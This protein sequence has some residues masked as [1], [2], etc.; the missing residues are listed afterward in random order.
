MNEHS[1]VRRLSPLLEGLGERIT[2]P[3]T[4][5]VDKDRCFSPRGLPKDDNC[6]SQPQQRRQSEPPFLHNGPHHLHRSTAPVPKT[7]SLRILG[8]ILKQRIG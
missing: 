1:G 7:L 3:A 2:Y 5:Q 4:D 6:H 8:R